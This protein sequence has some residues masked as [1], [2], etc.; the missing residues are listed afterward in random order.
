[1]TIN[2]GNS[3]GDNSQSV[4]AVSFFP[5]TCAPVLQ[6]FDSVRF[7]KFLKEHERY[8]GKAAVKKTEL[9]TLTVLLTTTSIDISLLRNLFY[10]GKFDEIAPDVENVNDLSEAHLKRYISALVKP[11]DTRRVDPSV[12]KKAL[13]DLTMSMNIAYA[14]GENYTLLCKLLRLS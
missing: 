9:R 11:T 12:I 2:P 1:M 5:S 7:Y 4:G 6:S 13:E 14:Q 3:D 8:E 10:M